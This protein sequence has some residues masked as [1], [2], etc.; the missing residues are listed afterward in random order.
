MPLDSITGLEL[1]ITHVKN[2]NSHVFGDIAISY[3][4]GYGGKPYIFFSDNVTGRQGEVWGRA[5]QLLF[6]YMSGPWHRLVAPRLKQCGSYMGGDVS[7]EICALFKEDETDRL[8]MMELQMMKILDDEQAAQLAQS[9]QE[10]N[11][12]AAT[13]VDSPQELVKLEETWQK[14]FD[15]CIKPLKN[16]QPPP[17]KVQLQ[18]WQKASGSRNT[19]P[20]FSAITSF[21]TQDN[22]PKLNGG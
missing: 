6:A 17:P 7:D 16:V 2:W 20:N 22:K 13:L 3:P 11:E 19:A 12:I 18:V 5:A 21:T 9:R 4:A 15:A 10:Y 14:Y 1:D 8:D